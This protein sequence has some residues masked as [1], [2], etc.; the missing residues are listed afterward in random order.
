MVKI[1]LLLTPF[2]V[3]VR[4]IHPLGVPCALTRK[5]TAADPGGTVALDG[6]LKAKSLVERPTTV[7]A[8]AALERLTVQV[9]LPPSGNAVGLQVIDASVGGDSSVKTT[10]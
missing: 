7:T 5:A 10:F 4:M 6:V 3:A 2:N 9:L 1:T 8:P